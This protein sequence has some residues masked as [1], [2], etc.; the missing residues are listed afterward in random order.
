MK[1]LILFAAAL[2]CATAVN[3]ASLKWGSDWVYSTDYDN[4]TA[5]GS[6]WLVYLGGSGV[7]VISVDNMGA[8]NFG[9]NTLLSGTV[10]VSGGFLGVNPALNMDAATWNGRSLAMVAYDSGTQMYGISDVW[11]VSGLA[12]ATSIP[13]ATPNLI[14]KAFGT[15]GAELHLNISAVPEPTSFALLAL[16]AAAIGLRRRIRKA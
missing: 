15:G 11:V 14:T 1:K 5:S 12:D 10:G 7:G 16:G 13:P 3:A 6:A 9:D 8:L 2:V 4:G